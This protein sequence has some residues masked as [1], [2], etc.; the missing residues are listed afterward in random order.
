MNRILPAKADVIQAHNKFLEGHMQQEIDYWDICYP[1]RVFCA[2]KIEINNLVY[3]ISLV[4]IDV[5]LKLLCFFFL[6][7]PVFVDIKA[8]LRQWLRQFFW[9]CRWHFPS[10]KPENSDFCTFIHKY[11]KFYCVNF[12]SIIFLPGNMKFLII[13]SGGLG[14]A[15]TSQYFS[16]R[17]IYTRQQFP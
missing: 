14:T 2:W 11:N 4:L 17:N 6:A 10:M 9:D 5:N 16:S 12:T 8:K 15:M 7:S 3:I 1:H 13:N